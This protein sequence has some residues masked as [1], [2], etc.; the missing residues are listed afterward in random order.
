MYAM[1]L[2]DER[3]PP[4]DGTNWIICRSF[5]EARA[6]VITHGIPTYISFDHDLGTDKT[7]YDFA[8]WLCNYMFDI[9]CVVYFE[10]YVHSQNPVGKKNIENYLDNFIRVMFV[11]T[12]D[13]QND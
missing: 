4:N 10:Y 7:G 6:I 11:E 5:E 13:R 1:F 8:K 2:D 9:N 12:L 3:M